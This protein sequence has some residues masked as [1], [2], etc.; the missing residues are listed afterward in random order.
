MKIQFKEDYIRLKKIKI[1]SNEYKWSFCNLFLCD[2]FAP[3]LIM[4]Y[5]I[6]LAILIDEVFYNSNYSFFLIIVL[7]YF[8][9]YL[10]SSSIYG[11]QRCTL[12]YLQT[13]F[14]K[15]IKIALIKKFYFAKDYVLSQIKVGDF[16]QILNYDIDEIINYLHL[17]LFYPVSSFIRLIITIII[18]FTIN[19]KVAIVIMLSVIICITI[20]KVLAKLVKKQQIHYRDSKGKYISLLY[21]FINN[22]PTIK[23]FTAEK[24]VT[25]KLE[26]DLKENIIIG[27]KVQYVELLIERINSFIAL[28]SNLLLYAISV[29]YIYKNE[30][31]IG[32]FIILIDYNKSL[33]KF[34]TNLSNVYTSCQKNFASIDKVLAFYE[35]E[36]ERNSGKRLEKLEGNII[37][38]NIW[39]KYFNSKELLFENL[40]LSIK[41]GEH[42]AFVGR[43]GIG[44]SSITSLIMGLNEFLDGE[45]YLDNNRINDISLLSLRNNISIINQ[46]INIFPGSILE[47]ITLGN[48]SY[49]EKEIWELCDLVEISNSIKKHTGQLNTYIDISN[50]CLSGGELQRLIIV[51]N[52]LRKSNVLILD[53]ATSALDAKIESKILDYIEECYKEKTVIIIAH[54]LNTIKRCSKIFI[55]DDKKIVDFGTHEEL[56]LRNEVYKNLFTNGYDEYEEK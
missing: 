17:N 55:V 32:Q 20:S 26:T 56:I 51:R 28:I 34:L 54:K 9:V 39:F 53:E 38:K 27:K 5:P 22:F 33:S 31:S 45:I 37:F 49:S 50:S 1:I 44:K 21:D 36:E 7:S 30:L 6:F 13:S 24:Q 35:I 19:T 18:I 16:V 29:Y 12:S 40:S 3:I 47:N 41:K 2:L 48:E 25:R 8:V 43:N 11:V 23:F 10:A 52:L 14:K 42:V 46:S 4:L 15:K